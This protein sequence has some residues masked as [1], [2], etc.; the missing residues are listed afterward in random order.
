MSKDKKS[1]NYNGETIIDEK[2]QALKEVKKILEEISRAPKDWQMS[3][4]NALNGI[5]LIDRTLKE[6][7]PIIEIY[8]TILDL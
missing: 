6:R 7:E 8:G 2:E 1:S 5:D 4:I 3:R